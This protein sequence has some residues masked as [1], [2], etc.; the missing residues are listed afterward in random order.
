MDPC[1][2]LKYYPDIELCVSEMRG[3]EKAKEKQFQKEQDEDFGDGKIGR[4]R[5][6]LWNLTEYPETSKAALILG[7]CSL[8][9]VIV[10]TITFVLG[11]FPGQIRNILFHQCQAAIKD[12]FMIIL[13]K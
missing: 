1:C 10:S 9:L 12:S 5:K 8:G 13:G 7:Y 2:A 11:T 3:E 6:Q 4:M